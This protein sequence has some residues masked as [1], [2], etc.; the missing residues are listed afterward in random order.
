MA[1]GPVPHRPGRRARFPRSGRGQC[2]VVAGRMARAR[3]RCVA[4]DRSGGRAGNRGAGASWSS[5]WGQR[6][7]A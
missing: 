7:G 2:R 6:R 5:H 1:P 3:G 4:A